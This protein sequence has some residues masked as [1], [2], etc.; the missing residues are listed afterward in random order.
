MAPSTATP[1]P[2]K[3]CPMRPCG[4][5]LRAANSVSARMEMSKRYERPG[6]GAKTSAV[7][8][9]NDYLDTTP[10]R[11]CVRRCDLSTIGATD[12]AIPASLRRAVLFGLLYPHKSSHTPSARLNI[13][14][15]A[16]LNSIQPVRS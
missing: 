16:S 13:L 14:T 10:A 4:A 5:T 8:D 12:V 11:H 3:V 7:C 1:S 15:S 2:S 9:A 6:V